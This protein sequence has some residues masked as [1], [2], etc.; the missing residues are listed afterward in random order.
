MTAKTQI[1]SKV[2]VHECNEAALSVLKEVCTN[3]NLV[4]LKVCT[5][6]NTIGLRDAT[7]EINDVMQSNVDLGAVFLSEDKDFNGVSGIELCSKIHR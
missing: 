2:L 3:N 5:G 6:N 7:N 1:V 4:G